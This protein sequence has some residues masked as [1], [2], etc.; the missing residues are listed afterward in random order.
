MAPQPSDGPSSRQ[1]LLQAAKR[2]FASQGYEQTAT[3]AIAREAGTSESQLMRYFGGKVGLLEA[4]FDEAWVD[5]N[6][7]A[8]RAVEAPGSSRDVILTILQIVSSALAR[9]G[10]LATLLLFEGRRLRSGEPRVQLS[11]GFVEFYELVRAV[12]RKGQ[13]TREFDRSLDAAAVTSSIMG[14]AEA[15]IRDRHMARVSGS[16]P[17]AEREIQRTL[18]TMLA[19]FAPSRGRI[20]RTRPK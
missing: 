11:K 10:E 12:V 19:G 8:K 13:S 2:L 15:M 9:D 6:L 18:S 16:R 4:L 7:R 3:S 14:A 20:R 17:F 1:R 5:L